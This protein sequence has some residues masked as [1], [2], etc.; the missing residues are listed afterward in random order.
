[1]NDATRLA[2]FLAE[3]RAAARL[4]HRNIV[5]VYQIGQ[6]TLGH[7]F[8]MEYVDGQSLDQ[9]VQKAT[10]PIPAAIAVV[11]VVADAV[12]YAHSKGIVHRDLKPANI[13]V[14]QAKRPV[15]MD[16]GIAKFVGKSSSLTQQ[17]VIMGTPAFMA[18]EQAGE[19]LE[20][21]GPCSDV[22]SLGAILYMLLTGRPPFDEGTTLRTILKVIGPDRAPGIR[23]LRP[24]VPAELERICMKC[25]AKQPAERYPSA[26]ALAEELR[27]FRSGK[28]PKK[29]LLVA[30]KR[31]AADSTVKNASLVVYLVAESGGKRIRV[32][33]KRTIIGR[34]SECG[35][36][37]KAS[38]VSKQHCQICIDRGEVIVE[39]LG[40]ANGTYV[41]DKKILRTGL[42]DGD[43]LRIADHAFVVK[44]A[45][46][47]ET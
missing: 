28:S 3:A 34:T 26:Q 23:S 45:K 29:P 15:V 38:D 6:C 19:A 13:M 47:K 37:L 10:I 12:H 31:S 7:Y 25:M 9:I 18:P 2:R 32:A 20:Q 14:D 11:T 4:D 1:L 36:I 40:S 16:F 35:V 22:Y 42:K 21:V 24:E 43:Q 41:N 39:D 46:P 27:L 5:Q 8:A 33:D 17:G 30:A 44:F